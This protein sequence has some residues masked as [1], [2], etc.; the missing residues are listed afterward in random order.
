MCIVDPNS[1][2]IEHVITARRFSDLHGLYV[3]RE[4]VIWVSS[5]NLD[6]VYR[7]KI[8]RLNHFGIPY[9][10]DGYRKTVSLVSA[11]TAWMGNGEDM[12]SC[13]LI[14]LESMRL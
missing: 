13:C 6:G 11:I 1:G 12:K 7:I 4:G 14:L 10:G 9:T 2:R 3:D 5:T 8:M